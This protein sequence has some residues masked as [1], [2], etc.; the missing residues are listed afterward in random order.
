MFLSASSG[1][2]TLAAS[3]EP[4]RYLAELQV[5]RVRCVHSQNVWLPLRRL[6]RL[7]LVGH[8]RGRKF[9]CCPGDHALHRNAWS[10]IEKDELDVLNVP[11]Q[12][13]AVASLQSGTGQ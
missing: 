3:V 12:R 9:M 4:C 13:L 2:F 10:D 5:R 1:V 8:Q 6:K 7:E 11:P